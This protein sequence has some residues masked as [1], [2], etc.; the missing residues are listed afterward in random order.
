MNGLILVTG[1]GG[2]IGQATVQ[3]LLKKNYKVRGLIRNPPSSLQKKTSQSEWIL[4]DMR[5]AS[6]LEKATEGAKAVIHLAARKSDEKDS[7]TVN[8]EG[9]RKLV[10]ACKKNK[11]ERIVN[12]S[13]QATLFRPRGVYGETKAEADEILNRSGFKVTTLFLSLVYGPD[14]KGVFAKIKKQ[15][16][17][18]PIIPI[19]GNGQAVFQPIHVEDVA[20]IIVA[21]LEKEI[22]TG[23]TYEVGGP[24]AVTFEELIETIGTFTHRKKPKIHIPWR[25][26]LLATR[27]LA[28]MLGSSPI[29]VSNVLGLAPWNTK[30]F[31]I[32]PVQRDLGI[33][34]MDLKKGFLLCFPPH[35]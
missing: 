16:A 21:C 24:N 31:D 19:I 15:L 29:T 25:L 2:F 35:S 34:P 5:E 26:G 8:V 32:Q 4:G 20:K 6:I 3:E 17:L 12:I 18:L 9:T 11:V 13:T 22:S 27:A 10:E 30:S 33:T 14:K 28:R 7:Y 23:R 1:A